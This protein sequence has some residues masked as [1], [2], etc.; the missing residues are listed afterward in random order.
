VG[1]ADDASGK[2]FVAVFE[3]RKKLLMVVSLTQKT[4]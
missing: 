2:C 1:T 4:V 3:K